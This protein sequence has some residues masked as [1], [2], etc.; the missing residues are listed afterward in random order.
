M[1]PVKA[2]PAGFHSITPSLTCNDAARAIEFYKNVFSALE[3]MRMHSP[4]GSK[5]T[6]AEIK[7]GDSVIFIN[8]EMGPQSASAPGGSKISL[9]LYVEDAD[10]TF[11]RAVEAG[12]KVAMPLENQFWGDR[13]GSITDPFGHSWGIATHVEDLTPEEIGRRAAAFFAK[14]VGK[15]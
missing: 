3:T 1:S 2:I 11:N 7:I 8:D 4:D 5:I 12:S 6:H 14:A 15:S 13:F 9:F 10:A